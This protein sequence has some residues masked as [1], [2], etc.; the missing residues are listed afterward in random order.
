MY[1]IVTFTTLGSAR[2][3]AN[4]LESIRRVGLDDRVEVY[5][6]D[7]KSRL[8]L[9]A[10]IR[11]TDSAAEIREYKP[12]VSVGAVPEGPVEWGKREFAHLMLSKL[13]LLMD[14]SPRELGAPFVPF[15]FVD[16]DCVLL[17]DPSELLDYLA[18]SALVHGGA[19][20]GPTLTF[21]SDRNDYRPPEPY[22]GQCC[23]GCFF[24]ARSEHA[25]WQIAFKWLLDHLPQIVESTSGFL[26]DQSAVARAL[27]YLCESPGTFDA[28]QWPN[29]ARSWGEAYDTGERFVVEGGEPK[30]VT[31]VHANWTVGVKSKEARL[32]A[33][34]LWTL[35][36]YTL[37]ECSL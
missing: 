9:E 29:G 30:P 22:K 7:D 27:E 36:E 11:L 24:A 19:S 31:L 34:G 2:L 37:R 17:E 26:S 33:S 10:F 32:L 28:Y 12:L 8:A 35:D 15:L 13:S 1:R 18:S 21:Q 3:C 5:C 20:G 16:A 25:L 23:M 14:L 6:L 4:L